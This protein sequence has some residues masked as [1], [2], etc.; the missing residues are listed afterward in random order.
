LWF[1]ADD[2]LRDL[3]LPIP[4]R[5]RAPAM[6][7]WTLCGTYASGQFTKGFVPDEVIKDCGGTAEIRRCL[8][9]AG[10]WVE[11][12]GGITYTSRGCRV[13]RTQTLDEYRADGAQRVRK[14]R[15]KKPK[16]SNQQEQEDV[17]SYT[18]ATGNNGAVVL[19]IPIEAAVKAS[20]LNNS[21]L[22]EPLTKSG[23]EPARETMDISRLAG[24]SPARPAP[25]PRDNG[26][27]SDAYRLVDKC[28]GKSWPSAIRSALAFHVNAMLTQGMALVD[29]E[30]GVRKWAEIPKAGPGLLPSLVAEA[31]KERSP[32]G[33]VLRGAD[34]KAAEWQALKRED[35][36]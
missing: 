1:N 2:K 12:D 25:P 16:G 4:K 3:A 22:K 10:F 13:P 36:Q 17:T 23:T 31:V 24:N 32:N 34:R 5:Y 27:S 29:I 7:V 33:K 20:S 35:D 15:A 28:G 9:Q 8:V 26:A 19:P 14:S 6:G 18:G 21:L 30:T 11:A